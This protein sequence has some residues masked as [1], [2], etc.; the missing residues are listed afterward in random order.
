M[1]LECLNNGNISMIKK[2][3]NFQIMIGNNKMN[4]DKLALKLRTLN[5]N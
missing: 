1:E 2:L 4:F 3:Q 5:V